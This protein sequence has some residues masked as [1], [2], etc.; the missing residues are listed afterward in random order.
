V[1]LVDDAPADADP[2]LAD[3]FDDEPDDLLSEEQP[4]RPATT[5]DA[6]PTATTN[7]RFTI[8]S[9]MLCS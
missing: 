8:C 5:I 6:P 9:P 7:P 2:E 1:T 4:A 3:E